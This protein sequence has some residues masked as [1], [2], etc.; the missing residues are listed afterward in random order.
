MVTYTKGPKDA[1]GCLRMVLGYHKKEYLLRNFR[2]STQKVSFGLDGQ[3]GMD[4]PVRHSMSLQ[5]FVLSQ[6]DENSNLIA[7]VIHA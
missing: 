2:E 1:M 5:N 4:A 7:R 6:K 3:N